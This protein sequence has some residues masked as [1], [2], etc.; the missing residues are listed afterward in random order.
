MARPDWNQ[1]QLPFPGSASFDFGC[2]NRKGFSQIKLQLH[3]TMPEEGNVEKML[4]LIPYGFL[5][6]IPEGLSHFYSFSFA[7][8]RGKTF[9]FHTFDICCISAESVT[10]IALR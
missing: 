4:A 2:R 6:T 7:S 9:S 10:L 1:S 5:F 3:L 8:Y